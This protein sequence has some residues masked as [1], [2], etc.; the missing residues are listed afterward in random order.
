MAFVAADCILA[1]LAGFVTLVEQQVL[2]LI[3]IGTFSHCRQRETTMGA[4]TACRAGNIHTSEEVTTVVWLSDAFINID[5]GHVGKG[6]KLIAMWADAPKTA[7]SVLTSTVRTVCT[8][9]QLAVSIACT[10]INVV[11]T[12]GMATESLLADACV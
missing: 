3:H 6:V 11:A 8:D 1:N 10:L 12:V 9:T 4:L 5:A 2:A 7:D